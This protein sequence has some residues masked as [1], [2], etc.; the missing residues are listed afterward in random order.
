MAVNGKKVSVPSMI[1]KVGDVIEVRDRPR[2]RDLATRSLEAATT[3]QTPTWL[4]LDRKAFV[5]TSYSI[6]YTKLYDDFAPAAVVT[7]EQ[8]GPALKAPLFQQVIDAADCSYN[9]V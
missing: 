9:F 8:S 7:R 1:L 6:H 5:I 3:Q 2:S 4:T